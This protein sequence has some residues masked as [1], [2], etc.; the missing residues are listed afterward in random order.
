[1][2]LSPGTRLGP[3]V[4]TATIGAGG[5]GEVYRARDQKLDR[6]VAVKIL[7]EAFA[8]DPD[9]L[10]R[11][12]REARTL[13]ALNH[14]NIAT[15]YGVE[16][17][18]GVRA[19]VM[20]LAD[21]PTL[22]EVIRAG[23]L[24]LDEAL[25]IARRVAD[26]LEA[27]HDHGIVHRDLKP[28][29]IKVRADGGVKVLDFGLAKVFQ[30]IGSTGA[31]PDVQHSPTM[32]SPAMT[33]IGVILGT[34][35]YM[36]PE[37]AKARPVD[38]RA[39]IWAFGCVLFEMLSGLRAFA[40]ETVTEVLAAVI[41]K[42]PDWSAMP[43]ATPPAIR[44][45]VHR[46]L[47]KDPRQRLQ[48]IGEARIA[49]DRVLGGAEPGAGDSGAGV[50]PRATADGRG[51]V[52]RF[53]PWGLVALLV[54]ALTAVVVRTRF[55]VRSGGPS[56]VLAYVPPP[57]GTSFRDFGFG[58][59]PVVVSPD[60]RQLAFSAI[61]QNGV[62]KLYVRPLAV[63][64][65]QAV[66]GT[67]DAGA[68]FWSPD[69]GSLG[70]VA[71]RKLKTV[72]LSNGGV[73]I[74]ADVSLTT[75]VAGGAWSPG[76]TI[77][78]APHGCYGALDKIPAAGGSPTPATVVASDESGHTAP[79]FLPDGRHF[80]Y[81][82]GSPSG[83]SAIWMGSTDSAARTPVLKNASAPEYAS[84]QL[85]FMRNGAHV[86]AQPM[87][88]ATG[89]VSGT[90]AALADA[91]SYSVS[92]AGVLAYQ[93]GSI[94]GRVEWLDRSGN[95]L[96]RVGADAVYDAVQIAPDGARVLA[97]MG[98]P[99]SGA[100]DLWSYPAAGG[101]GTRLTF[102]AG[103]KEF[104][105]WSPD[106]RYIA[107]SCGPNGSAICRKPA[108]GAGAEERLATP[109]GQTG[110]VVVDWSPDG[111][112]LSI[113]GKLANPPR[114]EVS[115]IA[116]SGDR[117]ATRVATGGADEYDGKFSPDGHWLAYF[118]YESG[119][120]EIYV[121]P[122][123]GPGGKF[124]ISQNGGYDV[125]WDDKGRLYF[126]TMGD[127]LME[128]DLTMSGASLQVNALHPLFQTTLPSFAAPFFD[129]SADGNR[130]LV[131]SSAAPHASGSIGVLLNWQATLE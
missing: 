22:E 104:A 97:E 2:P 13:A 84:G 71:D 129:V 117:K 33:A 118:S 76:G 130:F 37:Q 43:A 25:D 112:Y 111:R 7:P 30:A 18:G 82:A 41:A 40:G 83:P 55:G 35:A 5:M 90:P 38:R 3:Y 87:D 121:I 62:T 115:V 14:P 32:T 11:F 21:G 29:N 53:L 70:F 91:Q 4:V 100:T 67:E 78:F 39:D 50:A 105:T 59:G 85:L 12:E 124:Q 45:L 6:E 126:L 8:N 60:G 131:I 120:P 52:G 116:V 125:Q 123:P 36:A 128:A 122:F 28:A 102:G 96:G 88:P 27:A 101:V 72:N 26:A 69:G 92:A 99:A 10:M 95:E 1:M 109:E 77:L 44:Q 23:A 24:P 119:R 51:S 42:E 31:I 108:D 93:G 15:I 9:R 73:Q 16:E 20:E 63:E 74:L 114:T 48:A 54:I 17:A 19:L 61:D 64:N 80:L 107:Y 56:P 58:G 98:D 66:A 49:I 94:A 81:A 79:A 34:A 110:I 103:L 47:Q 106:G 89:A 68:P 127:R 113:N 57:T 75:C 65:A 86:F 46:C